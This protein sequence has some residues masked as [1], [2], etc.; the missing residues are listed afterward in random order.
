M[1]LLEARLQHQTYQQFSNLVETHDSLPCGR[2]VFDEEEGEEKVG[3]L[4]PRPFTF[5]KPF[6]LAFREPLCLV[7]VR[8]SKVFDV[9]DNLLPIK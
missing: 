3:G 8:T 2:W 7:K 9:N 4:E 5:S 1:V 6:S